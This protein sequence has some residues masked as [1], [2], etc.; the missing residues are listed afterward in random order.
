MTTCYKL[1]CKTK[2]G[3]QSLA[4]AQKPYQRTYTPGEWTEA[5]GNTG[6]FVFR[7]LTAALDFP[8]NGDLWECEC[9]GP[10]P[11]PENVAWLTDPDILTAYWTSKLFEE[12]VIP[13]PPGTKLFKRVKL[14]NR[15]G[16]KR[17]GTVENRHW[18]EK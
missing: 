15:L 8:L 11:T 14:T 1:V 13:C 4:V 9:E 5:E 12:A 10:L 7:E 18:L 2:E 16:R 6:L 3:Y 17:F